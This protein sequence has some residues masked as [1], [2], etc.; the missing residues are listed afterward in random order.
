MKKFV[1]VMAL[2]IVV[3]MSIGLLAAC[4]PKD[5]ASAKEKMEKAEYVCVTSNTAIKLIAPKATG[6]I[7]ATNGAN[8][9]TA[10]FFESKS[11]AKDFFTNSENKEDRKN[12]GQKGKCVY[13]GTEEAV[14]AL[15]K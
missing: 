13:F 1:K 4:A 15:L 12:I 7:I 14:K 11:D 6:G 3:V 5:A 10:L 8:T 2:A 9:V